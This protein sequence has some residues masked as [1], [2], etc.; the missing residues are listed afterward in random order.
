MGMP[1]TQR[2]LTPKQAAFAKAYVRGGGNGAKAAREAGYSDSSGA[3]SVSAHGLIRNPKIQDAIEEEVAK[4]ITATNLTQDDVKAMLIKE[5]LRDKNQ[6]GARI[7]AQELL[8]KTFAMF[9]DRQ[10]VDEAEVIEARDLVLKLAGDTP[11]AAIGMAIDLCVADFQMVQALK[12]E[13]PD[14]AARLQELL[15]SDAKLLHVDLD[16]PIDAESDENAGE[17]PEAGS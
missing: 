4:A 1:E 12:L 15:A 13:T 3:D 5:A 9:I 7:R 16:L 17:S 11:T 14:V 6:D 8:G 2:A 10:V